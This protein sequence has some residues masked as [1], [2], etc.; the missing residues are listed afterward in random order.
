MLIGA[1]IGDLHLDKMTKYWP[2]ANKR[3]VNAVL[4]TAATALDR[5][6]TR[7]FL[8]GD[9]ADGIKDST[10][11][12]MR[13]SEAGQV[14]FLRLLMTID[15]DPRF[16]QMES[17]DIILGN[18]DWAH[19]G[20][21]SLQVFI[22]MCNQNVFKKVRIHETLTKVKYQGKRLA[23]LPFPNTEPPKGTD[24]A[25]AHYEVK[26][27]IGDNGR[28]THA[29]NP[30]NYGVPVIQGHLHT[31]QVV[32]KQHYY[33]GTLYQT[34]FGESED[35]YFAT[36]SLGNKLAVQFHPVKAPFI[37]RNLRVN[38]LCDLKGLVKD[39]RILFKLFVQEEVKLPENL[40]LDYP[41]IVNR[42]DFSSDKEA[43]ALEA[44]EFRLENSTID[45][46]ERKLLPAFLEKKGATSTQVDRAM[47]IF[48][49][50][51]S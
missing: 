24:L 30:H 40:L 17:L 38:E 15:S 25:F 34:S 50:F 21:H 26:G 5:G 42:L 22:E 27:A 20:S 41:N 35:K 1:A 2:D 39:P 48:D 11:N 51:Y 33:P 45:I 12:A 14:Q 49:G 32:R 28:A 6:A 23:M 10:G 4:S 44:E 8:L 19:E 29:D 46:D 37:L 47:A 36:F 18:H 3:Q 31:K 16:S 7:L 13:L 43:E 9:I